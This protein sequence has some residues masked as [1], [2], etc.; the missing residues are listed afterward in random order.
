MASNDQVKWLD[1]NLAMHDYQ[2]EGVSWARY[3]WVNN[4]DMIL[5]DEMGLGKTIQ[6]ICF[7]YSLYKEGHCRGPFLVS[8]PLSTLINWER[9]FALWAPEFYVVSYIGDKDSRTVIRENELSFEENAVGK[10]AKASR[11][12]ASTVKFHVLLTSYEL[13]SIDAA[14]LG[15]VQWEVLVVDE[16]HR[17]KNA[18][19]KFFRFVVSHFTILYWGKAIMLL[20]R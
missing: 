16:A 6:T 4:T 15:S 13:I 14:C 8:V 18:Q 3:S 2:L 11:I 10:S 9:E 17:L 1:K 12:K 19:S 20:C 7:L 5:A